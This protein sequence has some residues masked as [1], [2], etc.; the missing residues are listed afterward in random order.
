MPKTLSVRD[1]QRR[2]NIEIFLTKLS[3]NDIFETKQDCIR[4]NTLY[5]YR[6][7]D[8][9][10]TFNPDIKKEFEA[11]SITIERASPSIDKFVVDGTCK[12]LPLSQLFKT[13]EFGGKTIEQVLAKEDHAI[14]R[15]R[16]EI[17]DRKKN[18]SITLKIN[19][20]IVPGIVDVQST[21]GTPKSDFHL[22]DVNGNE[23]VW[24]SHK[25]GSKPT[26]FQQ[27][28][29][30]SEKRE[31][32]I[33]NHPEV[34]QFINDVKILKPY[35]LSSKQVF[36]RK[37]KDDDLK[38]CSLY[39]NKYGL[40]SCGIQNVSVLAQGIIRLK[41]CNDYFE[42]DA[43]HLHFNGDSL[44]NTSYEPTLMVIYKSD[45]SDCGIKNGRMGIVPFGGRVGVD[46]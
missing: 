10:S 20:I 28:G 11:A 32:K 15:L 43:H 26:H 25:A 42:L 44:S 8:L 45:R 12:S 29:G 39:G 19:N 6:K 46:I 5:H 27:W 40:G 13:A 37:I 23:V 16:E 17:H 24:I 36:R 18:G 3:K 21:P 1:L 7:K 31:H 30:I 34:Q 9:V 41:Q 14:V 33:H 38:L 22:I 35:G 2:A 4:F